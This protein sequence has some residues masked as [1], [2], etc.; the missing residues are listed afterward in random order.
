MQ[1]FRRSWQSLGRISVRKRIRGFS[2][3]WRRKTRK[4]LWSSTCGPRTNTW[5]S[6]SPKPS[7]FQDMGDSGHPR[8][9]RQRAPGIKKCGRETAPTEAASRPHF[10]NR[11]RMDRGQYP[12][13]PPLS[14]AR[15]HCISPAPRQHPSSTRK[16]PKIRRYKTQALS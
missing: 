4:G 9:L 13:C 10:H 3:A 11:L 14:L 1:S 16:A 8:R 15:P 6:I 2:T 12:T 7:L 5:M